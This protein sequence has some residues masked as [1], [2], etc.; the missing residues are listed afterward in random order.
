MF[1]IV[2]KKSKGKMFKSNNQPALLTFEAN[3]RENQRKKL[4]NSK[5]KWFYKTILRNINETSLK[6]HI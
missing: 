2:A 3:L 6:R 1:I 4:D 5:E